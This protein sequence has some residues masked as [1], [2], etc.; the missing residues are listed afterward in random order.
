[1]SI[2]E[3]VNMFKAIEE[4]KEVLF[5]FQL[6]KGLKIITDGFGSIQETR[7][8]FEKLRDAEPPEIKNRR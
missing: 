5:P 1:L 6:N 4:G 3:W 8:F 7:A 2:E